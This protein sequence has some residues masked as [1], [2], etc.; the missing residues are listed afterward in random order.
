MWGFFKRKKPD[1]LSKEERIEI[2]FKE[3]EDVLRKSREVLSDFQFDFEFVS[4][5][6]Q[7]VLFLDKLSRKIEY[8]QLSNAEKEPEIIELKR[9]N[10]FGIRY[11]SQQL[12]I[13]RDINYGLN[14]PYAE[15]KSVQS[16]EP[17]KMFTMFLISIYFILSSDCINE[18]ERVI[19]FYDK[20]K[21]RFYKIMNPIS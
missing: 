7:H 1:K 3:K 6:L 19:P 4:E 12:G 16:L 13:Y 10:G 2:Y 17:S 9:M 15:E 11:D 14:I 20:E 18:D 21:S 5:D 8:I